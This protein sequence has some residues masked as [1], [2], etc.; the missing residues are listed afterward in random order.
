MKDEFQNFIESKASATGNPVYAAIANAY[1]VL[2]E[3]R[4]T[5]RWNPSMRS[6]STGYDS[7][8][9]DSESGLYD[10]SDTGSQV[11]QGSVEDENDYFTMYGNQPSEDADVSSASRRLG[12]GGLHVFDPN[13]TDEEP[14]FSTEEEEILGLTDTDKNATSD[15]TNEVSG[16][17]FSG[18][19]ETAEEIPV[20]DMPNSWGSKTKKIVKPVAKTRPLSKPVTRSDDFSAISDD[21]LDEH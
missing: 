7:E 14:E 2:N 16:D 13:N 3:A 12:V 19:V 11:S 15:E 21:D 17:N 10:D 4:I 5:G 1:S 20:A 18:E 6:M 9:D 8:V